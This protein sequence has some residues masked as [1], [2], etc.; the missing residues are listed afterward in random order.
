VDEKESWMSIIE[1]ELSSTPNAALSKLLLLPFVAIRRSSRLPLKE[2][3]YLF[4]VPPPPPLHPLSSSNASTTTIVASSE[5]VSSS[6]VPHESVVSRL[7]KRKSD[8][9]V[10][11]GGVGVGGDDGDGS[12]D[13]MV[14]PRLSATIQR[15]STAT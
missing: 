8:M 1:N 2:Q 10:D 13:R 12:N 4:A 14:K 7:G 5:V 11:V 9:G 3:S 15:P 6:T